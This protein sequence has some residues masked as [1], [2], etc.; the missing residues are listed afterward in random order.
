MGKTFL[1]VGCGQARKQNTTEV[2]KTDEWSELRYDIDENCEPDVIGTMTDMSTLDD[3]SFDAIYSSHN[4]EHL[5]FHEVPIALKEFL[6]VL[7][8]DGFLFIRCP[9]LQSLGQQLSEDK[10]IDTLYNSPI[11]DITPLDIMYGHRDS[12]RKGA[13][14]MAHKTGFTSK[15]LYGFLNGAGFKSSGVARSIKAYELFGF[16]SKSKEMDNNQIAN[17]FRNHMGSRVV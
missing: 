6:R 11:G 5:F 2:F 13:H 17:E 7:K 12:I 9:D 3:N 8:D 14:Y 4:I 1:H 16:A 15:I 10:A